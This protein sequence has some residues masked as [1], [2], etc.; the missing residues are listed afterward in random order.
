MYTDLTLS[1]TWT[2]KQWDKFRDWLK[3]ML[4]VTPITVTFTK[5]DGT[6]RVMNCTLEPS[7]LPI[8]ESHEPKKERKKSEDTVSVFDI[9]ANSW[10]S[11]TLKSVKKI[12]ISL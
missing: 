10:R 5:K 3:G 12:N 9:D 8:V 2:D 6:T 7:K 4:Q 1:T 11:F